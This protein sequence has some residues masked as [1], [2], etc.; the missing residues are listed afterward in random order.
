METGKNT[1]AFSGHRARNHDQKHRLPATHHCASGRT[2]RRHDVILVPALQQF[3]LGPHLVGLGEKGAQQMVVRDLWR[4]NTIGSNQTGCW[5]YKQVKLLI[6]HGLQSIC[7]TPGPKRNFDQC[8]E[9]V[10][11]PARRWRGP[12][13]EY[14]DEPRQ[15]EQKRSHGRFASTHKD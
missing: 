9:V 15:G 1:K 10:G 14:R 4:E 2:R 3:H 13:T 8:A 12:H 11:E 6:S 7:S 5:L